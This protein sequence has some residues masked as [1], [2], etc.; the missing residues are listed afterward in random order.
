MRRWLTSLGLLAVLISMLSVVPTTSAQ[1]G[2]APS[3]APLS[4]V[5]VQSIFSTALDGPILVCQRR[6][7]SWN[8]WH[9]TCRSLVASPYYPEYEA[10]DV[11]ENVLYDGVFYSRINGETTW[12]A[13][14]S[15]GYHNANSTLNEGLFGIPFN[16][17]I[18]NLGAVTV[19]GV[20][21]THYQY[22]STDKAYNQSLGGVQPVFDHFVAANGLMIQDQGQLRSSNTLTR[23]RGFSQHNT[24]IVVSPPPAN[25]VIQGGRVIINPR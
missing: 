21:T 23:I 2:G 6:I 5:Y 13:A 10:G 18:T 22:W 1:Q 12:N 8:R 7:E 17:V 19:N 25:Q 16:G 24:Q 20:A 11:V 14:S 15:E 4:S 9:D 3:L